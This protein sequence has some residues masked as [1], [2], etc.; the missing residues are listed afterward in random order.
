MYLA[1]SSKELRMSGNNESKIGAL[2]LGI[3]LLCLGFS[4]IVLP[5]DT[6]YGFTALTFVGFV[7]CGA[8]GGVLGR[9]L[10]R[11]KSG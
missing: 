11:Q 9:L 2:F 10:R 3:F 6:E 5:A 7:C 4:L 8:G 1:H